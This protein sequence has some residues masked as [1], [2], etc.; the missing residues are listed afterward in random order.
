M[1]AIA[2]RAVSRLGLVGLA[3]AVV[4]SGTLAAPPAA[5]AINSPTLARKAVVK[6]KGLACPF[7]VYGL[8]KH[9]KKLPGTTEVKVS[10]G[11]GEATVTFSPDSNVTEEQVRKAV[12]D[13][14]FTPGSIEWSDAQEK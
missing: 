11:K 1:I 14:G 12:R 10:L 8:E 5:H 2:S 13:A 9:L 7:C 4:A 3:L 6:V